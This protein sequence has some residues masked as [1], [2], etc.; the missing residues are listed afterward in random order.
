MSRR[1]KRAAIISRLFF[2][3]FLISL[4]RLL[5]LLEMFAMDLSFENVWQPDC[6]PMVGLGT[7]RFPLK[8]R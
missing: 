7:D 3:A 1:V 6:A 8:E 5:F 4:S 2:A